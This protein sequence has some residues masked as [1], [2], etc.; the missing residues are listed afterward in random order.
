[1]DC[2]FQPIGTKYG[3]IYKNGFENVPQ[4]IY[5]IF[6]EQNLIEVSQPEM[7]E[8]FP[9]IFSINP[10]KVVINTSFERLKKE[11]IKKNIEPIGVDYGNV[12]K[13]GGL[14]RCSTCPINRDDL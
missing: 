3:I 1:M 14:L 9:N 12:S 11:L 10:E 2:A 8:M 13:L 7:Y 6:G 5:D 4:P